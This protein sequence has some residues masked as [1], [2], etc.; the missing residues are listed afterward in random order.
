MDADG[1]N[2]RVLALGL[3]G[4]VAWSR[5]GR[6]LFVLASS[7][8]YVV[9]DGT[10]TKLV[11]NAGCRFAVSPDARWVALTTCYDSRIRLLRLTG[12][13]SPEL[14]LGRGVEPV[15]S[16]NGRRLAFQ[17]SAGIAVFALKTQRIRLLTGDRLSLGWED[18]DGTGLAWSPDSRSIAYVRGSTQTFADAAVYSGDLRVVTLRRKVRT[19]VSSTA[20]YGGRIVGVSWTRFPAGMRYSRPDAVATK[21]SFL[22]DGPIELLAADGS[23]V[24]FVACDQ[25][26][27][28]SPGAPMNASRAL[29]GCRDRDRYSIYDLALAGDQLLYA[30]MTGC[31]SIGQDVSVRSLNPAAKPIHLASGHGACGGP[32]QAVGR[33]VGSGSFLAFS[34]WDEKGIYAPAGFDFETIAQSVSRVEPNGCPCPVLASSPGPLFPADVNDGRLVVY[35]TNKTLVLDANGQTLLSVGISP[36][37]AQLAGSDLILV[38]Q[39]ELRD[40]DADTGSL[41]HSWRLPNA[42]TGPSCSFHCGAMTNCWYTCGQYALTVQDA[43]RGLVSYTFDGDVHVLRLPDGFDKVVGRGTLARFVDQGLVYADGAR[44]HLVPYSAFQ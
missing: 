9:R 44:L 32:F 35:G 12:H 34:N 28:W 27:T 3:A 42:F 40:L 21:D 7:N 33:L 1:R 11:T 36:L 22:A 20:R 14:V 31:N 18:Q 39:G 4:D 41:R 10:P 17:G 5:D 24:A 8:L 29:A 26:F 30:E 38:L 6:S 15:W 2:D 16:P 19:V 43:A 37:A 13:G 25:L 23:R